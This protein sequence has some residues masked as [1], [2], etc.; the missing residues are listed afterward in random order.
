MW[1]TTTSKAVSVLQSPTPARSVAFDPLE[2]YLAAGFGIGTPSASGA[3]MIWNLRTQRGRALE[4]KHVGPVTH[5]EF[6]RQ[7]GYLATASEDDTARVWDMKS[8]TP[9]PRPLQH[10]ADVTH[11]TISPD[12][13]RVMTASRDQ[14][15]KIWDLATGDSLATLVHMGSVS[16]AMF[17]PPGTPPL[18][19][20]VSNDGAARLWEAETGDLVGVMPQVGDV[21]LAAFAESGRL[22]TAGR[23]T[24]TSTRQLVAEPSSSLAPRNLEP[25]GQRALAA[26]WDVAPVLGDY[27]TA[28]LRKVAQTVSARQIDEVRGVLRAV[29]PLEPRQASEQWQYLD[30]AERELI[31]QGPPSLPPAQTAQQ[32]ET[33]GQWYAAVWHLSRAIEETPKQALLYHRR[34]RARAELELWDQAIEDYQTALRLGVADR[35]VLLGLTDAYLK[36]DQWKEAVAVVT[37]AVEQTAGEQDAADSRADLLLRRAWAHQRLGTWNSAAADYS[38]ALEMKPLNAQNMDI[39][40][41]RHALYAE[42]GKWHELIEVYRQAI[43]RH[44]GHPLQW[45]LWRQL[46]W[47]YEAAGQWKQAAEAYGTVIAI[48]TDDI[49]L[50]EARA[51]AHGQAGDMQA[52]AR[53][54]QRLIDVQPDYARGHYILAVVHLSAASEFGPN[55][56]RHDCQKML[57][58]FQNTNDSRTANLLAWTCSLGPHALATADDYDDVIALAVRN[59]A[60]EPG[61]QHLLN[62]LGASLYRAGRYEEAI[63][64]LHASRL[65]FVRPTPESTQLE[66]GI[67]PAGLALQQRPLASY[68]QASQLRDDDGTVWDFLFLAMSHQALGREA[69]QRG[70]SQEA[71]ERR[72]EARKWLQLAKR[73]YEDDYSTAGQSSDANDWYIRMEVRALYE[74]ARDLIEEP[75]HD[76]AEGLSEHRRP[77]RS[78]VAAWF[79]FRTTAG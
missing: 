9:S 33:L 10:T 65:A 63:E 66:R 27:S 34:A 55:A 15:A 50:L 13:L 32:C 71:Q 22:V 64:A 2:R 40:K 70:A 57:A 29:T 77:P 43:D 53:D 69:E 26:V 78:P 48:K 28:Q 35:N 30:E 24:V 12:E 17:S 4:A 72:R 5:V 42:A 52:A 76:R 11:V 38:Q 23:R 79:H 31:S 7:G 3:V 68:G 67:A 1:D 51:R 75:Q 21:E 36:T 44:A 58:E 41:Q 61:K 16:Q 47:A 20:T 59:L 46:A 39:W 19:L 8:G 14:T 56:Y 62:T 73:K 25:L 60:A 54:L 49:S 18:A 74:E 37:K 45:W 6:S